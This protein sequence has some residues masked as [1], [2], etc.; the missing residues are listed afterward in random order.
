M[1]QFL[2]DSYKNYSVQYNNELTLEI[3]ILKST[4][5]KGRE[6]KLFR[7]VDE[8]NEI[9]CQSPPENPRIMSNDEWSLF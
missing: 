2:V 1:L 3:D 5:L 7:A 4:E 9:G 6:K 8:Q